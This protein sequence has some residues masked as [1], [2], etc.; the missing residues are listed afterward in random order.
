MNF[1]KVD[2]SPCKM[3]SFSTIVNGLMPLTIAVNYSFLDVRW[4]PGYASAD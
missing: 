2:H 3:E 1:P 4:V